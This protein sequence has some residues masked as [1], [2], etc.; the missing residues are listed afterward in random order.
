MIA[1]IRWN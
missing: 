1:V